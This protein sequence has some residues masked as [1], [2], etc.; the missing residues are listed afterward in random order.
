MTS[1]N[2]IATLPG[3]IVGGVAGYIAEH[4]NGLRKVQG[5]VRV[6]EMSHA[7]LAQAKRVANSTFWY[8]FGAPGHDMKASLQSAKTVTADSFERTSTKFDPITDITV[9]EKVAT[10]AKYLVARDDSGRVLGSIGLY[11]LPTDE[12]DSVWMGWYAVAKHARGQKVG[13]ALLEASIA[14]AK[15]RGARY[16]K[17]YTSDFPAEASAGKVYDK[18]GFTMFATAPHPVA[19]YTYQFFQ[20]DLSQDPKTVS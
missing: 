8:L 10:S 18:R 9:H 5:K 12:R 15:S 3:R 2:S 4:G 7:T 17:L 11:T 14:D 16:L 19:P 1:N 6:E 20:L 13:S